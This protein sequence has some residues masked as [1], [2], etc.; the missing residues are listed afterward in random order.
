M[1][2]GPLSLFTWSTVDLVARIGVRLMTGMRVWARSTADDVALV[3]A[4]DPTS[5]ASGT[6]NASSVSVEV[7]AIVRRSRLRIGYDASGALIF[8]PTPRTV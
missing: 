2:G 6:R 8:T 4:T 5:T 1:T 7:A 3:S